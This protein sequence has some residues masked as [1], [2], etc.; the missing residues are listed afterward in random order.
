M[1]H[2]S[3]HNAREFWILEIFGGVEE[4]EEEEAQT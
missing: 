3:W 4:E 1:I 2:K